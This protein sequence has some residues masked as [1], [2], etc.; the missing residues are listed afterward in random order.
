[1]IRRYLCAALLAAAAPAAA[2]PSFTLQDGVR[3]S[4]AVVHAV[5]PISGGFRMY[6]ST[7]AHYGVFSAS[8]TD[9]LDWTVEP[10]LRLSTGAGA[11]NHDAGSITALGVYTDASLAGGPWRAYYVGVSTNGHALLSA[12]SADG[13]AWSPDPDLSVSFPAGAQIY[14]VKPYFAGADKVQLYYVRDGGTPHS[15]DA[16]RV[17]LARSSDGG[18]TFSG[19]T[20][21]LE[22]TGVW[23]VAVST[24]TSGTLRLYAAAPAVDGSTVS[25]VLAADSATGLSFPTPPVLVFSTAAARN[26]LEAFDVARSTDGFRWRLYL[27]SRLD[28]AATSY[29]YS[30][31]TL[32]P[33]LRSV[34][35]A[36]VYDNDAAVAFTAA[37]EIFDPAIAAFTFTGPA[38]LTINSVTWVSD[39]ELTVNATPTGA[40]LGKY[41]ATAVNPDGRQGALADA[42][43]V[44]YR[45]GYVGLTDNLFRPL[46]GGRARVDATIFTPG[47]IRADVYTINGGLVKKL[48]DAPAAAGTTT[49]FW[50]GSTDGGNTAASGLYLL[51]VTGPKLKETT[52][53]VLIK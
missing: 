26:E 15:A 36:A 6:F 25:R 41:T 1:M 10:G 23:R 21:A 35:P 53:I 24:L 29:A 39:M 46:S 28:Q 3:L 13:L 52:R 8:S 49:F 30:A 38:A 27:T 48:Y 22:T 4:S 14:D 20:L 33:E 17:Y 16:R 42:L 37:G 5:T 9:G 47:V 32:S 40:P 11:Y 45:P 19:E 31:L 34:S 12:L 18:D 2:T 43:T 51:H 7:A 50:N 44:D